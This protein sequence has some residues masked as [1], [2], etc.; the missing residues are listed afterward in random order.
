[1]RRSR[2]PTVEG[3]EAKELLTGG[4][5][6]GLVDSIRAVAIATPSG[7]RVVETFV[8]TNT[9]KH[10]VRFAYGPVNEGFV[11]SQAGRVVYN[12]G[13]GIL[14]QFLIL[15]T[16]KPHQ[17]LTF[18]GTWDVR[19]NLGPLGAEGPTLSGK[20]TITNEL[21]PRG[22]SATVTVAK[23]HLVHAKPTHVALPMSP[24]HTPIPKA[25]VPRR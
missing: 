15:D 5:P 9:S 24:G 6:A 7:H 11:A 17:S 25:G 19:S 8:V 4:L 2:R 16:I 18:R 10:D 3:L 13:A 12:P 21:D 14:P 23:S 22:P 20:F 1:M